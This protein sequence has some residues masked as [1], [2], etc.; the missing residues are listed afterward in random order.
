MDDSTKNK[1]LL[2]P[3]T[4]GEQIMADALLALL[5]AVVLVILI[6]GVAAA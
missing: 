4:F 6:A 2:V 5:A 1:P 3:F